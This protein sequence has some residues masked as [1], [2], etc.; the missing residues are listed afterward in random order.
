MYSSGSEWIIVRLE[1]GR[2]CDCTLVTCLIFP[3]PFVENEPT[4]QASWVIREVEDVS[5]GHVAG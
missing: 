1:V 4:G 5:G 3:G 2:Q